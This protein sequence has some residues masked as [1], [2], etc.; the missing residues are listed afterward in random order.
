M[1][2]SVLTDIADGIGTIT[3]NRPAKLNA[4]DGPMRDEVRRVLLAWNTDP[5]V[6]A[7]IV[8]GAD[9]RAFSAGQD[10]EETEKI[11]G[12]D[13]GAAWF[14]SWRAFYDSMRDLDKPSVAA[15]SGVA[16]GSA[17]QFALLMDVR[18]GH[19]GSSMGQT[20]INSGIPS[21]LGP[22]LM[23]SRIGFS[24]TTEAVLAGRVFSAKEAHELGLI[25]HMVESYDEVMPKARAVAA[26]LAAKPPMAMRLTKRSLREM[27]QRDYDDAFA[28]GLE[29]EATAYEAGEPQEYMRRFFAE[30][31]AKKQA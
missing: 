19:P 31:Q 28:R 7:I 9:H 17:F 10:L 5:A 22:M 15:L 18:V 4:W 8:T 11:Q 12:W 20:E 30:R 27:T 1:S 14:N 2:D 21:V 16:A 3:L 29:I 13:E 26:E 25:H 6:K 24:R 23:N